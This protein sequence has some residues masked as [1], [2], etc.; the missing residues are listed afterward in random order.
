MMNEEDI[1]Q[2]HGGTEGDKKI[3]ISVTIALQ[4]EEIF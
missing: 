1:S 4:L 2:R 3:M